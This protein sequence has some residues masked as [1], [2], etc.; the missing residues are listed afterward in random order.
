MYNSAHNFLRRFFRVVTYGLHNIFGHW[1]WIF[2]V[3]LFLAH[4]A[5]RHLSYQ[6]DAYRHSTFRI[7]LVS[8]ATSETL[9]SKLFFKVR[10]SRLHDN[11]MEPRSC[12][13][14]FTKMKNFYYLFLF[15]WFNKNFSFCLHRRP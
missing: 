15:W 5:V 9:A 12:T 10:F 14:F 13:I 6:R 2:T 7:H 4:L 8:T 11:I 3:L 1:A